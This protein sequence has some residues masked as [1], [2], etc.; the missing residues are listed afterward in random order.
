[1]NTPHT[2]TYYCEG[3]VHAFECLCDQ[4]YSAAEVWAAAQVWVDYL[5]Q[6]DTVVRVF[7]SRESAPEQVLQPAMVEI[8]PHTQTAREVTPLHVEAD[9]YRPWVILL[10]LVGDPL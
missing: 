10:R 7:P 6:G 3:E 5:G 1:M 4:D 2:C 9:H 8:D